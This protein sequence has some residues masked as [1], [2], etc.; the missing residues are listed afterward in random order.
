MPWLELQSCFARSIRQR[1][2]AS[3]VKVST[4]VEH[5]LLHAFFFSALSDG[6][7]N[8][9]GSGHVSTGRL[10]FFVALLAFGSAGRDQCHAVQVINDLRVDVVKRAINVQPRTLRRTLHLAPDPRVYALTILISF[11][12][13]DHRYFFLNADSRPQCSSSLTS[14]GDCH[15]ERSEESASYMFT[16]RQSCRPSSSSAP[17]SSERPC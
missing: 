2:D 16:S 6:L 12:I 9:F 17:Q 15:S 8:L 13:R 3:V 14:P 1:F 4:A 5:N 10:G 11:N 7:A